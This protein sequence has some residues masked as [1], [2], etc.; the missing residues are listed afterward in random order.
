MTFVMWQM[1][2]IDS[3]YS[4]GGNFTLTDMFGLQ[5]TNKIFLNR[6]PNGGPHAVQQLQNCQKPNIVLGAPSVCTHVKIWILSSYKF[7][8]I[9]WCCFVFSKPTNIALK[10]MYFDLP[11]L[12]AITVHGVGG[13]VPHNPCTPLD[14]HISCYMQQCNNAK[15][16][17]ITQETILSFGNFT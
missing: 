11:S 13:I 14:H 15:T 10:K 4:V 3:C 12:H 9:A 17:E 5:H 16:H 6:H 1:H 7:I 8:R 2:H